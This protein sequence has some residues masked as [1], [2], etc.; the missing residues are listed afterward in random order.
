MPD[1]NEYKSVEEERRAA[2]ERLDAGDEVTADHAVMLAK[3]L[4]EIADVAGMPDTYRQTD[5]RI[6][7][8]HAVLRS[9]G[10]PV[11]EEDDDDDDR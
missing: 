4:I 9:V 2:A 11:D 7:L 6:Q 3:A 5:S 8:A 10:E 1:P